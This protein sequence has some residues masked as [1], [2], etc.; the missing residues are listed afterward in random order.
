VASVQGFVTETDGLRV[1]TGRK[2]SPP[3]FP[4]DPCKSYFVKMKTTVSYIP[5]HY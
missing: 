2:G 4:I 1:Y 5:S 3:D